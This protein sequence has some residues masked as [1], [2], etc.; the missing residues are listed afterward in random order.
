MVD[1]YKS[2][3]SKLETDLMNYE[4]E[5]SNGNIDYSNFGFELCEIKDVDK[6][7]V[8]IRIRKVQLNSL[9]RTL[10]SEIRLFKKLVH[11]R[12]T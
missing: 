8:L 9:I 4:N 10:K 7:N 12:P 2:H 1:E 5:L 3:I 6:I 11:S